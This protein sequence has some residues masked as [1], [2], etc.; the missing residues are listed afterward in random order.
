[1]P[2]PNSPR[3]IQTNKEVT[4][5]V[6]PDMYAGFP[7]SNLLSPITAISPSFPG[8]VQ[9]FVSLPAYPSYVDITQNFQ[10]PRYPVSPTIPSNFPSS[11]H[12]QSKGCQRLTASKFNELFSDASLTKSRLSHDIKQI[13]NR[14]LYC[15]TVESMPNSTHYSS[16]LPTTPLRH[17]DRMDRTNAPDIHDL[18]ATPMRLQYRLKQQFRHHKTIRLQSPI[19]GRKQ[20]MD[21]S[22]ACLRRNSEISRS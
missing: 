15:G 6:I 17:A 22:R 2:I 13:K 16:S 5:P 18:T 10:S 19:S 11:L 12:A 7:S 8:G 21:P 20:Q 3:S 4:D 1:M 9:N 14:L